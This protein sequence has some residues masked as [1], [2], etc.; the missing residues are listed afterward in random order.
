[1]TNHRLI[2][3]EKLNRMCPV[4]NRTNFNCVCNKK[5]IY[6]LC[7]KAGSPRKHID[8]CRK[9]RKHKKCSAFQDYLQPELPFKTP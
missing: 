1:M 4:C 9:C 7:P 6:L 3:V 2:D 8:V 5:D